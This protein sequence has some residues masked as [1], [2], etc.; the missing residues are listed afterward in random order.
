M[1]QTDDTP[2]GYALKNQPAAY[3]HPKDDQRSE[4][5]MA[6]RITTLFIDDIDGGEAEGTVHFGLDGTEYEIDLNTAHSAELRT[7]L[8]RYV[9][10]ARK[11]SGGT[12]RRPGRGGRRSAHAQNTTAI[13]SW[14][15]EQGIEIKER[16][17]IPADVVVK[18]EAAVA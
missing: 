17:R 9:E 3:T 4:P 18:Y 7:A 16:G 11:V 14:A 10:H 12:A 13:R 1:I 8:K 15:K 6:Q 5:S 2:V